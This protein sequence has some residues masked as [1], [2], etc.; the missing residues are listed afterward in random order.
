MAEER[1]GAWEVGMGLCFKGQD[2]ETG[3]RGIGGHAAFGVGSINSARNL[4][5]VDMDFPHLSL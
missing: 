3:E 1:K 4:R 2:W 5:E